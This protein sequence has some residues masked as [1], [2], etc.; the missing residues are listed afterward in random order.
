MFSSIFAVGGLEAICVSP[1]WRMNGSVFSHGSAIIFTPLLTIKL[2]YAINFFFA[3]T[4]ENSDVK[5]VLVLGLSASREQCRH[6]HPEWISFFVS[7]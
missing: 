6:E 1:Q 4:S 2:E 5:E 3:L 7:R